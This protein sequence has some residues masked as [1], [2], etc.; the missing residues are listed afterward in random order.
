MKHLNTT[1]S[2]L[3][4]FFV[5]QSVWA[6]DQQPFTV[7]V[8]SGD[9][10][11]FVTESARLD[12]RQSHTLASELPSNTAKLIWLVEE[13]AYVEA[14]AQVARFDKTPFIEEQQKL[15]RDLAD[16]RAALSQAEAELQIAIRVSREANAQAEHALETAKLKKRNLIEADKPLR[17]SSARNEVATSRAELRRATQELEVQQEMLREGFGSDVAVEQ[18]QATENERRSVLDHARQQ[19]KL[20]ETVVLPGE[21]RQVTLELAGREREIENATQTN[22]HVMAKQNAALT[23]LRNQVATLESSV[24]LA[25]SQLE[26]TTILAPVSG[27]VIFKRISVGSESRTAQIGDSVWNRHGFMVIPDMSSMVGHVEVRER[28]IGKIQVGQTV[29]LRPEAYP[30]LEL[31]GKIDT[32]GTL[33]PNNRAKDEENLFRVRI[34]LDQVDPRLRPGMRAR[35]KILTNSYQGV[36]RV[37]IEAVF[38]EAG[39]SVCFVW[40]DDEASRQPVQIGD[41]DG[42]YVVVESGLSKGDAVL[43]TY[44]RLASDSDQ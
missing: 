39:E 7:T 35:A 34:A 16:A 41:T 11:L 38:Y 3:L 8:S 12:T 33:A 14:G 28:D 44:P 13:G 17:L 36:L 31:T 6:K 42:E 25:K 2:L 18:A 40:R 24:E 32:V 26:K 29:R 15:T 9:F 5:L 23:R 1:I 22:L 37:P 27:F 30:R 4:C 43:L 21:E 10:D 20:L 19:L